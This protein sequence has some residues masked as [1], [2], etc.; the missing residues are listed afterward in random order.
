MGGKLHVRLSQAH[1][2][3]KACL[4]GAQL[5][6]VCHCLQSTHCTRTSPLGD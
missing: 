1:I 4:A 3:C 6:N 5:L 2:L